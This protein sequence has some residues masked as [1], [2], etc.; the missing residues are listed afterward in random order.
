ME[1]WKLLKQ[2]QLGSAEPWNSDS[3]TEEV[4]NEETN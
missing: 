3:F 2:C 1:F 4:E